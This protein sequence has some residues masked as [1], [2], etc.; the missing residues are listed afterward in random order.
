MKL[1]ATVILFLVV[2]CVTSLRIMNRCT[3]AANQQGSYCPSCPSKCA[4]HCGCL[5][6]GTGEEIKPRPNFN[7]PEHCGVCAVCLNLPEC[8]VPLPACSA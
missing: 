8:S 4:Y 1:R 2:Q 3:C 6:P 5:F 7:R